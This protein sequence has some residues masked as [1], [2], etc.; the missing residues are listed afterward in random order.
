[1]S[2]MVVLANKGCVHRSINSKL[3]FQRFWV[4]FQVCVW[5]PN[6]VDIHFTVLQR[7]IF[8]NVTFFYC[9]SVKILKGS[10]G[11]VVAP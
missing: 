6:L 10:V 2:N 1:M 8:I 11:V 4:A 3:L 9:Q 5:L 7:M